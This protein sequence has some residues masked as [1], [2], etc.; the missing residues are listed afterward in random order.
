MAP[1]S[2]VDQSDCTKTEHGHGVDNRDGG[3]GTQK[4]KVT[5]AQV[6]DHR[7]IKPRVPRHS[8]SF[9]HLVSSMEISPSNK[10]TAQTGCSSTSDEE[11]L[12][13][14]RFQNST[15]PNMDR[16]SIRNK[17][18]PGFFERSSTSSE[19][20]NAVGLEGHV[21]QVVGVVLRSSSQPDVSQSKECHAPWR[22]RRVGVCMGT[23]NTAVMND[24]VRA[25]VLMKKFGELNIYG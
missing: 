3:S 18:S 20:L 7:E 10:I 2:P 23:E 9:R 11:P 13:P 8:S 4:R 17:N 22:L 19:N 24:R 25:R 12:V 14:T 21:Y 6:I 16:S 15:T 5:K 1:Y